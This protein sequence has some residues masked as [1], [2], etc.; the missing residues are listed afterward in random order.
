MT[1]GRRYAI[2]MTAALG[3][4]MGILDN[5]II[6]IALIP[7]SN[8]LKVE[9]S[10]VQWLVTGDFLSQAA[11]IPVAGYL[12]NRYGARRIFILSIIFFTI[13]SLIC[14]LMQDPT[15]LIV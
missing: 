13:G 10:T 12:S 2:A 8:A 9:L 1:K 5:T 15:L 6:N 4:I 14:G 7:I 11:V 3:L